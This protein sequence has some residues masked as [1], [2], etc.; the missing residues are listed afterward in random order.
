MALMKP[1]KYKDI[2]TKKK[3]RRLLSRRRFSLIIS[4]GLRYPAQEVYTHL[5]VTRG[6]L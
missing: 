6:V 2:D 1:G 4:I 5:D 3:Y